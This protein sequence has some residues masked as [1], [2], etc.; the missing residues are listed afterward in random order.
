MLSKTSARIALGF[1]SPWL[2]F[3]AT[4]E[5]AC[6]MHDAWESL[7]NVMCQEGY[8]IVVNHHMYMCDWHWIMRI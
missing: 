5:S 6:V 2:I 7:C 4:K 8:A 1:G 3:L